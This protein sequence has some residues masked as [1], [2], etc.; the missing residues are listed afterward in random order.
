MFEYSKTAF[1]KY[2]RYLLQ[3]TR[4]KTGF[5]L[6]PG[7]G[8]T[9]LE[10]SF[11]GQNILD[12]YTD[13][14]ELD[15][16]DWMKNTLLYPFPNRLADGRY[17]WNGHL[18]QFAINDLT[19]RNALHGFVAFQKFKVSRILLTDV[20]AEITCRYECSG[21]QTGYPF[22]TTLEV[23]YGISD[24]HRFRIEF[25][26]LNRHSE[27]IPVGLGW[28]PYFRLTEN[29][30]QTALRLP[31]SERI[32]INQKMLPSG[33][34]TDNNSYRTA[35]PLGEAFLDNC[36]KIKK[37]DAIWRASIFG[38][39]KRL[40]LSA[41]AKLWPYLQVFTPPSRNAIALEPMSCNIDGFNNREGLVVLPPGGT[42]RG[43]AFLEYV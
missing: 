10:I 36:F 9:L 29:V 2:K 24:N 15:S 12:A 26:V 42:W 4:T 7:R 20:A 1:G 21:K 13:P 43:G 28:H 27:A 3:N 35:I 39:G 17:F 34:R 38:G 32:E 14:A 41:N 30:G 18:N 31:D 23:T 37:L 16:M 33:Q 40:T 8:A 6:V 19:T 22:P 25:S 11:A 5:A